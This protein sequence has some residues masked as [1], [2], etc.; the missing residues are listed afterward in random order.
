M[1]L[2]LGSNRRWDGY[3]LP[4]VLPNPIWDASVRERR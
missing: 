4:A 3:W 1:M 2:R